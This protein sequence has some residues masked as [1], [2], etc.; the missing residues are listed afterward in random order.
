MIK[1]L[2]LILLICGSSVYCQS[3][4]Q[5]ALANSFIDVATWLKVSKNDDRNSLLFVKFALKLTPRSRQGLLLQARIENPKLSHQIESAILTSDVKDFVVKL[6]AL[7]QKQSNKMKKLLL[8]K[9]VAIL[10]SDNDNALIA[11]TQAENG[12]YDTTIEKLIEAF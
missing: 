3:T 12:K 6:D 1:K 8:Y 10:D 9:F 2:L 11:I 5:T 4:K 7:A